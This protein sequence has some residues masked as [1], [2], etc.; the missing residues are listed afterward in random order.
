MD[1]YYFKRC[2]EVSK[3]AT[4]PRRQVGAII[5]D[6]EGREISFG[7]NGSPHGEDH[8]MDAGCIIGTC[9]EGCSVKH[10]GG[11]CKRAVHAEVNTVAL[12]A[13]MGRATEGSTLYCNITV[14]GECRRVL[15]NAG[16]TTIKEM[17][18][19]ERYK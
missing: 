9:S 15:K 8:C 4:C 10:K 5:I 13:R 14:C 19:V 17:E 12:A 7:Y 2:I 3:N 16:I 1:E 11:H 18:E 6:P